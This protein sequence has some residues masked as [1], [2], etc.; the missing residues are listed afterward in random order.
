[1]AFSLFGFSVTSLHTNTESRCPILQAEDVH[2]ADLMK[3]S[4]VL[5]SLTV[6]DKIERELILVGATDA[7]T[8]CRRGFL[9]ALT[10]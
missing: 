8:N 3:Y 1:M 9:S 2:A 5:D 10:S 7:E 4:C 6:T